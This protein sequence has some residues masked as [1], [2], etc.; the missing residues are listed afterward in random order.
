MVNIDTQLHIQTELPARG[1]YG[2]TWTL[3]DKTV[4]YININA[5]VKHVI[6]NSTTL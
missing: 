1:L 2:L 6:Q 3:V 5:Y 4:P